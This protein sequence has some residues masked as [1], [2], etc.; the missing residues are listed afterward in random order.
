MSRSLVGKKNQT[1]NQKAAAATVAADALRR[2]RRPGWNDLDQS[3]LALVTR[4]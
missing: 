3:T 1:N 2:R 4:R